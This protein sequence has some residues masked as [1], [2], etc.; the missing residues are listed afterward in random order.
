MSK[1]KLDSFYI[2]Y[3]RTDGFGFIA[4]EIDEPLSNNMI[5]WLSAV[6]ETIVHGSNATIA[7]PEDIVILYWTRLKH[8]DS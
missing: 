5:E 6:R 4:M 3:A 7:S 1:K 8:G 2:S